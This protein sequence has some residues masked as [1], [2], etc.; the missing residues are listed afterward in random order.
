MRIRSLE[1]LRYGCFTDTPLVFPAVTPDIHFVYGPNEAGK[2]TVRD[3]L[4]DLLFGF[5]RQTRYDFRHGPRDLR[6][7]ATLEAGG[8]SLSFLRRK[9]RSGTILTRDEQPLPDTDLDRLL[10]GV[11]RGVFIRMFSLDHRQL[12]EGGREILDARDEIG[13]ILFSAGSGLTGLTEELRSL[14]ETA[15]NNWSSRPAERRLFYQATAEL[16]EADQRQKQAT[17]LAR[18]WKEAQAAVDAARNKH[19]EASREFAALQ[20]RRQKLERIRRVLPHLRRRERL[21]AE[22]EAIGNVPPLPADAE[23]ILEETERDYTAAGIEIESIEARLRED[24]EQLAALVVRADLLAR[25]EEIAALGELRVVA[26]KCQRDLPKR[27]AE[28]DQAASQVQ[29]LLPDLGWP[30]MDVAEVSSRLP[31]RTAVAHLRKLSDDGQKLDAKRDAARGA[32]EEREAETADIEH[33]LQGAGPAPPTDDLAAVLKRARRAGDLTAAIAQAD[34]DLSGVRDRL[35]RARRALAPWD[36][37]AEALAA[38][39]P[40][41]GAAIADR[42][43]RFREL[44]ERRRELERAVSELAAEA[45]DLALLRGQLIRDERAVPPGELTEARDRRD[46]GW[47]FLRARY[48]DGSSDAD[49]LLEELGSP[50]DPVSAFEES[51]GLADQLADQRFEHAESAARLTEIEQRAERTARKQRI[52]EAELTEC[53]AKLDA[54]RREWEKLCRDLGIP[55]LAPAETRE[56][57]EKRDAVLGLLEQERGAQRELSHVREEEAALRSALLKAMTAAGANC[58]AL[59]DQPLGD[60]IDAADDLHRRLLKA[61]ADRRHKLDRLTEL[62]RKLK[63]E[64]GRLAE[65]EAEAAAWREQWRAAVIGVSLDPESPVD[66]IRLHLDTFDKLRGLAEK[67]EDLRLNRIATMERDVAEFEERTANLVSVAAPALAGM[68]PAD[69][70]MELARRLQAERDAAQK[71][72]DLETRIQREEELLREANEKRSAALRLVQPLFGIAGA[73]SFAALRHEVERVAEA[74]RKELELQATDGDLERDGDGKPRG[75]LE[76]ECAGVDLDEVRAEAAALGQQTTEMN[77]T[78]QRLANER[79]AA[80]TAA[81]Q[82][83]GGA[84]AAQAAA[85]RQQALARMRDA[86]EQYVRAKTAAILLRWAIDRFRQAK[87][88]PLLGRAAAMFRELT[89]G[90][91]ERLAVDEGEKGQPVLVGIRPSGEHVGV[92]GMSAG[93]LDQLYLALRLAAVE[94]NLSQ[95][96]RMPFVADD[97]FINF[98]EDRAA[99]GIRLLASLAERTQVLFFTHHESLLE[100]AAAALA[101]LDLSVIRLPAGARPLAAGG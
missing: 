81:S 43:T 26:G 66:V 88:A 23:R 65:V 50:S 34:L 73:D 36:G 67:A 68:K 80:E 40:P 35:D 20:A 69:A 61:E 29:V 85:N 46:L 52:K 75:E 63:T 33:Q 10:H 39:S 19:E 83:S 45:D 53:R 90:G 87:Q 31:G 95:G 55:P 15:D 2:S 100:V 28:M 49:A 27:I 93:T 14:E 47:R 71:R 91:F 7:G 77:E 32:V 18:A 22:R 92:D 42:E 8:A 70:V 82:I 99:T 9:G 44:V 60:L 74:R 1:L 56:W 62:K 57:L 13:Q 17:V 94:E 89:L 21:L 4:E 84:D 16:E 64:R 25:E 11:D 12:Q 37:A 48:V 86:A 72:I 96:R 24:K 51:M 98:D 6:I 97:L 54:E 3:S 30:P 41:S 38:L 58:G 101:R 59:A 5:R 76:A 78:L 79:R